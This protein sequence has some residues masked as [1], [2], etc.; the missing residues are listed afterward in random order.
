MKHTMHPI[1]TKIWIANGRFPSRFWIF[2]IPLF[3]AEV[4]TILAWQGAKLSNGVLTLER[5]FS[6]ERLLGQFSQVIIP[7]RDFD[8]RDFLL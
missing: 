5:Q 3:R 7:V 8:G 6:R 1:A 2:I 4:S